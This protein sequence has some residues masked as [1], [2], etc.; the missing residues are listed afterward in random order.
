MSWYH[1]LIV[2]L[3]LSAVMWLAF[4]CRKYTRGVADYLA[5]G[6]VCGRYVI[7]VAGCMDSLGLFTIIAGFEVAYQTGYAMGFWNRI[8]V[9]LGIFLSLNGYIN[10]RFRE[11]YAISGGQFLE[12]RYSRPFRFFASIV[13]VTPVQTSGEARAYRPNRA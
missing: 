12:M 5:A 10:Y 13:R 6:R 4:H 8:F 7:S 2:V 1:W 11:T 3:P 9:P